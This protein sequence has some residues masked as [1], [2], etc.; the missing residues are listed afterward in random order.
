MRS[1]KARK[2]FERTPNRA[3]L[4]GTGLSRSEMKK[5][6]IGIAS[7]FSDL[8]PGHTGMRDLERHIE[9]GIYAGGG[10]SFIFGVG[11]ICDGIAMG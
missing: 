9:K 3:L 6:A 2:G 1:D 8:V 5:P 10:A 7:S 4:Y 11:A